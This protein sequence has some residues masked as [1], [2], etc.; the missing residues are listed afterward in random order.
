MNDSLINQVAM[1]GEKEVQS[2]IRGIVIF[3][4]GLGYTGRRDELAYRELLARG[5]DEVIR[6]L[7]LEH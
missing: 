1:V 5:N 7:L 4:N 6:F 3:F 2:P